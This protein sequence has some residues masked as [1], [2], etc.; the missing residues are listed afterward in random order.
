MNEAEK[1]PMLAR[2][3]A[4]ARE[5]MGADPTGHDFWHARRVGDVS[6]RI[7]L[8]EGADPFVAEFAGLLHDVD[9]EKSSGS[10]TAG[11]AAIRAWLDADGALDGATVEAVVG[12]AATLS[13]HGAKVADL[14]MS[15]E[16]RC[17]RDADRLDALGAIGVARAFA[18]G[19]HADRPIHEPGSVPTLADSHGAYRAAGATTVD[20]FHEKL[21]LLAGRTTTA[22]GRRLA[23]GRHAYM[24]GFLARFEAEWRGE[25]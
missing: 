9:D 7:A 11:P 24:A 4:F 8:A 2:A 18:Y 6:R 17:V 25:E 21:L 20:H 15:P 5:R 23:A 12:I 3:E 10:R 14:P 1:A 22:E 19:G 16:G 13:F